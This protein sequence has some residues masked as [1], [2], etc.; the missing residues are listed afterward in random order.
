MTRTYNISYKANHSQYVWLSWRSNIF[1]SFARSK[2][3]GSRTHSTSLTHK[4][5]ARWVRVFAFGLKTW[6]SILSSS[7]IL[8][9][10]GLSKH[11]SA[12]RLT[13]LAGPLIRWR[14]VTLSLPSLVTWVR[15]CVLSRLHRLV[16]LVYTF[17]KCLEHLLFLKE[18]H[19]HTIKQ[20]S[21]QTIIPNAMV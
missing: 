15:T 7:L 18:S 6:C 17:I 4:S 14:D 16:S 9:W 2:T 13:L 11:L 21:M 1:L 3:F 19:S 8:I 12:H 10:R 20:L 5:S